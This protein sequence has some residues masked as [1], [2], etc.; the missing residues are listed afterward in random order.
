MFQAG[1]KHAWAE[2]RVS[3]AI[4]QEIEF[5]SQQAPDASQPVRMRMRIG[6]RMR[7]ASTD[8]ARSRC[9]RTGRPHLS[10]SKAS[11]GCTV[12]SSLPPKAPPV[13][14][15]TTRM[16]CSGRARIARVAAGRGRRAVR[17]R[18]PGCRRLRHH[19]A[20]FGLHE[21][22]HLARRDIGILDDMSASAP[23]RVEIAAGEMHLALKIAGRMD[24]RR[25]GCERTL[26][27]VDHGYRSY[28][29]RINASAP[30]A[31]FSSTAATA[32]TVS[33]A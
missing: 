31:V 21:G 8:S 25:T 9:R 16:R 28:S 14:L 12:S 29:T 3:A 23:S 7:P 1:F 11:A 15:V 4:D 2:R 17:R 6:L 19:I 26:H 5:L 33:P 20:S 27:I 30:S 13:G 10:T 18:T 32:A 24:L 22:V